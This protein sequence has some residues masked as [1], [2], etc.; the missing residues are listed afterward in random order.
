MIKVYISHL[1]NKSVIISREEAWCAVLTVITVIN[2][3]RDKNRLL[4]RK[5]VVTGRQRIRRSGKQSNTA[6]AES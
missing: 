2:A 3:T 6:W 1:G 5:I 4:T